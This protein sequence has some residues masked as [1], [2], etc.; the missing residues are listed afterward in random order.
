MPIN[1]KSSITNKIIQQ[2][3]NQYIQYEPLSE[4]ELSTIENKWR[5]RFIGK[6]TAPHLDNY[7]WHIF[8]Y[9]DDNRIEGDRAKNEYIK[10]YPTVIYIF[11]ETLSF[12]LKCNS[13]DK[14]PDIEMRDCSDDIYICHHNMKWTY[15]ITH[16]SP[17]LGPYFSL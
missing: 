10:Q 7:K 17:D 6:R 4:Q 13:M 3:D 2:L 15:V 11:N 14:L 9:H 12:G 1:M 5:N 16:E 8:S